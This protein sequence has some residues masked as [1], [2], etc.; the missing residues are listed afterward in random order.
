LASTNPGALEIP[1]DGIDNDCDEIVDSDDG[2]N[3]DVDGDGSTC[4][5]D[6]DDND[7]LRSPDFSEICDD[8]I[9]NDCDPTT[10]DDLDFDADGF[11]CTDDCNDDDPLTYP[12]APEICDDNLDQDC[13]SATDEL[14]ADVYALTDSDSLHIGLCSFEFRFCDNDWSDLYVQDNGR[15]TF[16]FDDT[17]SQEGLGTFLTQV[18]QIAMLWTDLDPSVAGTVEVT[19]VDGLSLEI[20]FTAI[21]LFG[22]AGTANSFTLTLWSDGLADISYGALD[23][24]DGFVGF[25]C[26]DQDVTSID[27]SAN[28]GLIGH[29][30]EDAIYE[31]FSALGAPNDLQ[32]LD[33][34]LCLSAGSDADDDGWT[35][36]CG[37]CDDDDPT[38]NPGEN[39][40]CS[41]LDNDCNGIVDDVDLD[42]DG[43]VAIS[44][45]GTDCDDSLSSV[46]PGATEACNAIDDDCDG[47]IEDN[48]TDF[49]LDGHLL[50]DGDCDDG[51]A[52]VYPGAEEVCDLD[53]FGVPLDNDCNGEANEGF[54]MDLDGDGYIS[55]ECGGDDCSDERASSHP[56]A[57]EICDLIDNNCD[58]E[59]DNIDNDGDSYSDEA[60]SGD[61]CDDSDDTIN[62]GAEDIPY[63]GLDNDCSE[64]DQ[65][66]VDG[67]G[68][69][70]DEVPGGLDCDDSDSA[71]SPDADEICDDGRDNDCDELQDIDDE[72]C[73]ACAD[74]ASNIGPVRGGEHSLPLLGLLLGM[75]AFATR[76]QRQAAK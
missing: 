48:G 39:E 29:G 23:A 24:A 74:C 8:L 5:L 15:V 3:N 35:D 45:S 31:Q 30:T 9:D 54:E 26:G 32:G 63:D 64:G 62:P 57:T 11:N 68:Y 44:C 55:D 42:G 33:L 47:L 1:C 19:E 46:Y 70:S 14:A 50:C 59:A 18:P 22:D 12:G 72:E 49:D 71:I 20:V 51:N 65:A 37:D 28:Q 56:G 10:S 75:L 6:C 4:D 76:R 36:L 13:D 2:I 60:C 40:T 27:L 53:A 17:S 73:G 52:S 69:E 21:P 43:F 67:D 25:A 38:R 16:G 58:G 41:G 7:A 66:D 34:E 61:D